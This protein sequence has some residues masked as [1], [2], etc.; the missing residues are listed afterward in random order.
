M[1]VAL[2][3]LWN[4]SFRWAELLLNRIDN[5]TMT[6]GIEGRAPMLDIDVMNFALFC[7][8]DSKSET[9][10]RSTYSDSCRAPYRRARG[11][12]KIGFG[13]GGGNLLNREVC[14]YLAG[15]LAASPSYRRDPL[16]AKE[17]LADGFQL[18][19]V[20]SLHAW[21]DNWM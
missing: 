15:K 21:L 10:R 20:T 2:S 7:P 5:F 17:H 16:V 13:G 3:V 12:P 1:P 4:T 6:S 18:F 19:T 9:G 11:A 14:D 8:I